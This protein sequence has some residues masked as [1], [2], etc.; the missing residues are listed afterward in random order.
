MPPSART[1]AS[2]SWRPYRL[3][4]QICN[5]QGLDTIGTGATIAWLMECF[6]KG[7]LTEKEIG[8]PAPFGDADAMIRLTDAIAARI[9]IGDILANGSQRA[10]RALGKGEELLITVKGAEAPAHMPQAKRSLAL[11]YAVNPFGADHQSS[12]HDPMIEEGASD[13]YM[14]RLKLLGFDHTLV[15]RSLDAEKVRL[16]AQG[17]AVLLVP[18]HGR[19]V[20][21]RLGAGLDALRPSGDRRLRARGHR[22]GG[23]HAG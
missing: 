3:A 13:L 10:A 5:D 15:P 1:A 8:F 9:G 14:N 21:V 2:R 22:L 12:E 23:L 11:I 4:N 7:L 19:A 18:G 20:P 17:P 16:R 6:E